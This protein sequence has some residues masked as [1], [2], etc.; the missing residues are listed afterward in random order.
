MYGRKAEKSLLPGHY[1]KMCWMLAEEVKEAPEASSRKPQQGSDK[2]AE[3]EMS[4][5]SSI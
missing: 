2:K 5:I 3:T 4:L 1:G